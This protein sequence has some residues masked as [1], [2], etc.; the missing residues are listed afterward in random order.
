M[1]ELLTTEKLSE[2]L[3]VSRITIYN[4]RKKGLPCIKIGRTV[5]F[6]LEKVME[7]I[8]SKNE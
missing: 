4:W 7:W 6:D 3:K 5:R 8:E 2:I 1:K